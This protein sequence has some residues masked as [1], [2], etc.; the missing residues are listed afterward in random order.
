MRT[1]RKSLHFL[2][3]LIITA[4]AVWADQ[5]TKRLAVEHL[6]LREPVVL[7]PGVLGF[8]RI[9]NTGAAFGILKGH[10]SLFYIITALVGIVIL[11]VIFRLPTVRK[12]RPLLLA[13][14]LIAAGAIGN[15]IDRVTRKSVI[16]FI[17]FVPVD[18]PVFNVADIFVTCATAS[19]MFLILFYYRDEEFDFLKKD[20]AS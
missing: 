5:F 16:D 20:R 2:L 7:I 18:F 8:L 3:F 1:D 13:L 6:K 10:M 12:Y 9:E 4:A 17:Y 14:S 15:L 19:L 11:Y